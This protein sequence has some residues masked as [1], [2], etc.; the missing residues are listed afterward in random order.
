M[1]SMKFNGER[2][3]KT[4]KFTGFYKFPIIKFWIPRTLKSSVLII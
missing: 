3:K 4:M 1:N 2:K